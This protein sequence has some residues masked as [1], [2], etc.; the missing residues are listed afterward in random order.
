PPIDWLPGQWIS[1]H[2]P[3]GEKPPLVRAYTLAAPPQASGELSLCFDRVPDGLG[4]DYLFSIEPGTE[5][6]FG[7]PLGRFT[8]PDA[9]G[10]Q[11]WVAHFTGIVPFRAMLL[12]LRQHP[13]AGKVTLVYGAERPEALVY[14]AELLRLAEEHPWFELAATLTE[15]H[16][17]WAGHVG[18]ELDLLPALVGERTDLLPMACGKRELVH[19]VRAFFQERGYDRRAVKIESYD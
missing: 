15:P 19:E 16:E 5:L 1:L 11:V 8:L 18:S 2:L 14:H 9:D 17:E 6:T 4:S 7:A 3:V 13:P 12:H 10:D